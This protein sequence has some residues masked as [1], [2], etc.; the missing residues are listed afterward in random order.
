MILS[1][2]KKD[3]IL[4]V[5]VSIIGLIFAFILSAVLLSLFGIN[6]I[7]T[8]AS[9]FIKSFGTE[10]GIVQTLVTASPIII[11]AVGVELGKR[12]GIINLGAEGQ[13]V[14]GA[15]GAQIV[16]LQCDNLPFV[17]GIIL[18]IAGGI[19]GGMLYTLLP[20]IL[21]V[22]LGINEI[23]VLI[24]TN[25]IISYVVGWLVRSP[26]KDP[27]SSNN[28]GE[29]ISE[30]IWLPSI[31]PDVDI[32]M[33]VVIAV[34]LLIVVY[35]VLKKTT[36]GY[37]ISIVGNSDRSAAYAGISKNKIVFTTFLLSGGIIGMSGALQ[38]VGVHHRLTESIS[39]GYGWSGIMVAMVAGDSPIAL[40]IVAI[41]YSA[42]DVGNTIIQI[43]DKVPT[44]LADIVQAIIVLMIVSARG[45]YTIIK[46][47]KE[48]IA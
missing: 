24:M 25:Q 4:N 42:L 18:T 45:T 46:N 28:Q 19:L 26:L 22:R 6:P 23:V 36:L 38:V 44:Q 31:L 7:S 39:N 47:R 27:N 8:F 20:A 35:L 41:L 2:L 40:V 5:I 14:A 37:E 29:L 9:I 34:V 1:I 32:H 33:G 10:R 16:A 12:A 17:I 30:K 13:I 43:T 48:G 11:V 15:I 21:K 3:A